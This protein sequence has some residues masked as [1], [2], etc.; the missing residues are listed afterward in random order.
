MKNSS[1]AAYSKEQKQLFIEQWQESGMNKKTFCREKNVNY[2]TFIEW[3]RPKK[4][5]SNKVVGGFA[6]VI[7]GKNSAVSFA[8]I[9]YANGSAITLHQAVSVGYLRNLVK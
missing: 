4:K 8:D 9:L 6:P 3:T 2:M 1:A 7:V 5:R